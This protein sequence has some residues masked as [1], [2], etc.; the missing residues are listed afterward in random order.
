MDGNS[1]DH[2]RT[3]SENTNG[4]WNWDTEDVSVS[5]LH[6]GPPSDELQDIVEDKEIA[7]CAVAFVVNSTRKGIVPL[8]ADVA[9]LMRAKRRLEKQVVRLKREV[10]V[11]RNSSHHG[12]HSSTPTSLQSYMSDRGSFMDPAHVQVFNE[13]LKGTHCGSTTVSSNSSQVGSSP[14][15]ERRPRSG[16]RRTTATVAGHSQPLA[17]EHVVV[18]RLTDN[19]ENHL[20]SVGNV[21]NH[22]PSAGADDELSAAS[23]NSATDS[24]VST[25]CDVKSGTHG[26]Q[27]ATD[28]L[29]PPADPQLS[30]DH[31][32]APGCCCCHSESMLALEE[33]FNK[34]LKIN[35]KLADELATTRRHMEQ[36]TARLRQFE[37]RDSSQQQQHHGSA[38]CGISPVVVVDVIKPCDETHA[39]SST[40]LSDGDD[41]DHSRLAK[42]SACHDRQHCVTL[43]HRLHRS[44]ALLNTHQCTLPLDKTEFIGGDDGFV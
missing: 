10:E 6:L 18:H 36:L 38:A 16:L 41:V 30:R 40:A 13:L 33:Q 19:T 29:V 24:C 31:A 26:G 3:V 7:A 12:S 1:C 37:L 34:S 44:K 35:M 21:E 42:S 27:F 9:S 17:L 11:L 5:R 14:K 8:C 4:S 25:A 2:S 15:S 23:C 28:H 22:L 32:T 20:Q 43:Q 39:R